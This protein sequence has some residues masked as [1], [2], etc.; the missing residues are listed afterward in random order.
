[1]F[2]Q[3]FMAIHQRDTAI[4]TSNVNLWWYWSKG[5]GITKA[6]RTHYL[7]NHQCLYSMLCQFIQWKPRS[8]S[9]KSDPERVTKI[10]KINQ[11]ET[12]NMC[13]KSNLLR[14]YS[15]DQNGWTNHNCQTKSPITCTAK[16]QTCWFWRHLTWSTTACVCFSSEAVEVRRRRWQK[17]MT[18]RYVVATEGGLQRLWMLLLYPDHEC[19]LQ[20]ESRRS[21][22]LSST[23][24]QICTHCVN[25]IPL[26]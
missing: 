12:M 20:N 16:I 8:I 3:N 14:Y 17:E 18:R 23:S 9:R 7:E 21:D 25:C 1:M 15:L 5:Q 24:S 4:L 19:R 26:P 10:T 11:F 6:I 13:T 22:T 2:V